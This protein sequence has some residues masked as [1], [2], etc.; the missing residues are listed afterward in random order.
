MAIVM[1]TVPKV[2]SPSVAAEAL[3]EACEELL[4]HIEACEDATH[5]RQVQSHLDTLTDL[6]LAFASEREVVTE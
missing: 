4:S 1:M 2:V 3:N 5:V 6:K